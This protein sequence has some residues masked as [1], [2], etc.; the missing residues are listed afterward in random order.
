MSKRLYVCAVHELP[1]GS[2]RVVEIN[3]YE[4]AL[5]LN[6]DGTIYAISNICPHEGAALQRGTVEG[7]VL[8]CPLH[9]WGFELTTGASIDHTDIYARPYPVEI[10]DDHLYLDLP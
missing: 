3:R 6:L 9:R 1:P 2:R 5:V 10:C 4:E 7:A 8:Y